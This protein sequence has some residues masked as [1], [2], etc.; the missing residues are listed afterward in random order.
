MVECFELGSMEDKQ[1]DPDDVNEVPVPTRCFESK[2]VVRRKVAFNGP[3]Q[4]HY[5]NKRPHG[6][7]KPV[8]TRQ[9]K[10]C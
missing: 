4:L 7:V 6:D 3:K 5:E 2:A 9:Q 1:T 10:E 8:E